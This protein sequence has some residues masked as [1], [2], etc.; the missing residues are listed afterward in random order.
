MREVVALLR[1]I[2]IM[3]IAMSIYS[4]LCPRCLKRMDDGAHGAIQLQGVWTMTQCHWPDKNDHGSEA[5]RI[6]R[7][8][9]AKVRDIQA[10]RE[11]A[12]SHQSSPE[13]HFFHMG[14]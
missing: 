10:R 14:R 13:V 9:A 5:G 4:I 3:S 11:Q 6:R 2:N 1:P 7:H 12:T 8:T